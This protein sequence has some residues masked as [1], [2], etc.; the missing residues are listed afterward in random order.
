MRPPQ[1]VAGVYNRATYGREVGAA[2]ALW[3]DHLRSIVQGAERKIV[4][5]HKRA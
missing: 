1:P 5:L 4:A 3:A 2:L